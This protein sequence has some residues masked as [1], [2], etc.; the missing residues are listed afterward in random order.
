MKRGQISLFVIVSLIFIIVIAFLINNYLNGQK[1]IK[2]D[3]T[4]EGALIAPHI[5]QAKELIKTCTKEMATLG[6]NVMSIQGGHFIPPP[7]H[8]RI[9]LN[10]IRIWIPQRHKCTSLHNPLRI[11]ILRLP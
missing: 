6:L 11:H 7:E 4:I 2:T 5:Q 8:L 9:G 3:Q 10:S 1:P